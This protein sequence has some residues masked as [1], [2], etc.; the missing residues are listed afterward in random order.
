MSA[1]I[2]NDDIRAVVRRHN[3]GPWRHEPARPAPDAARRPARADGLS[4]DGYE[5]ADGGVIQWPDDSGLIVHR[6]ADGESVNV[7]DIEDDGWA[8]RAAL[9]GMTAT[10]FYVDYSAWND[11][12][13]QALAERQINTSALPSVV[14]D[15]LAAVWPAEYGVVEAWD[16]DGG[17][18]MDQLAAVLTAY[19]YGVAATI[20]PDA[21]AA[22]EALAQT[23]L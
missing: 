22:A 10:D 12:W 7:W 16:R 8:E 5:L 1:A 6:D 21:L 18:A 2:S 4:D 15:S 3:H 11:A 19:G 17:P 23:L 13:A 20:T 14:R 9:F